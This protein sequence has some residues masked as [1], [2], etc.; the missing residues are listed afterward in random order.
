MIQIKKW[1]ASDNAGGDE[2]DGIVA[3]QA[4]SRTELL[5]D[6]ERVPSGELTLGGGANA[7]P[8]LIKYKFAWQFFGLR[9][10][11]VARVGAGDRIV[12]PFYPTA[13]PGFALEFRDRLEVASGGTLAIEVAESGSGALRFSQINVKRAN[14]LGRLELVFVSE[15]AVATGDAFTITLPQCI[16]F[17][18]SAGASS[19]EF[20][21][22]HSDPQFAG[23]A[24]VSA[25]V[26]AD[27]TL[28]VK[29][30]SGTLVVFLLRFVL[31]LTIVCRS[32]CVC[33]YGVG[34]TV[35][36]AS[37]VQCT[38]A[39]LQACVN[40]LRCTPPFVPR[41]LCDP[42]TGLVDSMP[43]CVFSPNTAPLTSPGN[44][45]PT[46]TLFGSQKTNPLAKKTGPCQEESLASCELA[47]GK[48][49]TDSTR[50]KVC[51]CDQQTGTTV[52]VAQCVAAEEARL[53]I[54]SDNNATSAP[55]NSDKVEDEFVGSVPFYIAIFG[56]VIVCAAW[57]GAMVLCA[58]RVKGG[59]GVFA[60]GRA[61]RASGVMSANARSHEMASA[62]YDEAASRRSSNA[63][64][65]GRGRES[66]M[67]SARHDHRAS[68]H[69]EDA[70]ATASLHE[71]KHHRKRKKDKDATYEDAFPRQGY[72]VEHPSSGDGIYS[73]LQQN[74]N[75]A[76]GDPT[77][78]SPYEESFPERGY[79]VGNTNVEDG[80]E[81]H[82][83]SR[84]SATE[85]TRD[86][87][88]VPITEAT[89]N[90]KNREIYSTS[91][92]EVAARSSR[93][94]GDEDAHYGSLEDIATSTTND[95]TPD[96]IYD[97]IDALE[98]L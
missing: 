40:V 54:P 16:V 37:Q 14:L 13:P 51:R 84:F 60:F 1:S 25:T 22:I 48:C 6:F 76:D 2:C 42:A 57:V 29:F 12:V 30:E 53:G 46:P 26:S 95:D 92:R 49:G 11:V 38:G 52:L 23:V 66:E 58:V 35:S 82:Y 79:I 85:N 86:S 91:F 10:D 97:D 59:K 63:A 94:K 78:D 75:A 45:A 70:T 69:H 64:V 93:T 36:T 7:L 3:D 44:T 90:A 87:H 9:G 28:E 41:C 65:S 71:R 43:E 39:V 88:Y 15:I 20:E 98:G 18:A 5:L 62:R 31:L 33:Q 34:R 68:M 83:S 80:E 27:G 67:P 56:A 55:S 32:C 19:F 81:G 50:V 4:N 61:N 21:S 73:K 17:D 96:Q 47:L 8:I 89:K 24:P 72:V 77:S 74:S